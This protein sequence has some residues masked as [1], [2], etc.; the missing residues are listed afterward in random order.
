MIN[1]ETNE[2]S[3]KVLKKKMDM[4]RCGAMEQSKLTRKRKIL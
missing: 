3:P 2:D 1:L 4:A